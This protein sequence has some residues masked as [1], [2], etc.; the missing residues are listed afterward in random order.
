[1]DGAANALTPNLHWPAPAIVT[2]A[3]WGAN[4]AL[5]ESGQIFDATV[6]HIVVHHTGT[7]N[8]VTDYAGLCRGI[9]SN[10]VAGE[11]IDIAY[12]W[13]IDPVGRI[14]EGRWAKNYSSG[15]THTGERNNQNVRGGHAIYHNT[16][17]IGIA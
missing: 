5:R 9:Y 2:R 1:G 13:L 3:Q 6:S 11:Y 15:E 14:Y 12:N 16:S 7:P 10:E 17:T 4:E 8:S